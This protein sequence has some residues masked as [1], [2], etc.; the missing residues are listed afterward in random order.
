MLSYFF[1]APV[2]YETQIIRKE[3]DSEWVSPL[4]MCG[5]SE[6]EESQIWG[7]LESKL[8]DVIESASNDNIVASV[9]FRDLEA[10]EWMGINENELYAPASLL[11]LPL[12]ITIFKITE[13]YPVTLEQ[14]IT[15]ETELEANLN[16]T[17]V[18]EKTAEVGQT[19]TISEL[20][21]LMIVYSDNNATLILQNILSNTNSELW[22]I[23]YKDLGLDFPAEI[24]PSA[25]FLST[26]AF[27]YFF[28]I[29]YNSSYLTEDF[30]EKAL[31]LLSHDR[32]S[33]GLAAGIPADVAISEKFGERAFKGEDELQDV[34]LHDCGIIYFPEKP[35]ILCVMTKGGSNFEELSA[36]I[37]EISSVTYEYM[38]RNY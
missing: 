14:T 21:E 1:L 34:Q 35:Y 36:L 13:L 23:I 19:Y 11:K 15:Y 32:F 33:D 4:L 28:R 6:S 27:S 12:L 24:D 8:L 5:V 2:E 37:Q 31:E 17:Y 10:S 26:K 18:P 29:L 16:Q 38:D 9:Y 22:S 25:D 20:I 3:T 7:E 30:S